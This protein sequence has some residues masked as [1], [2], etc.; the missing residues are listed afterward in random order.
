MRRYALGNYPI[1]FIYFFLDKDPKDGKA[2]ESGAAQPETIPK[3]FVESSLFY[4]PLINE[5]D[6]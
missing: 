3:L 2:N 1:F 6:V 5:E 4:V